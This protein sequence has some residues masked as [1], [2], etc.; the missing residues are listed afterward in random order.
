MS[1]RPHFTRW[2]F[3]GVTNMSNEPR[4]PAD[5]TSA[6]KL[7]TDIDALASVLRK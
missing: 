4:D 2:S 3:A 5:E 1:D 7:A 6:D